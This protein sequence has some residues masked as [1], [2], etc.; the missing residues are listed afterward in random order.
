MNMTKTEQQLIAC[1]AAWR[2]GRREAPCVGLSTAQWQ[3]LHRLARL[4]K[5]GA[6]VCEMLCGLPEFCGGDAELAAAWRRESILDTVGQTRRTGGL[7]ELTRAL[8][9]EGIPYAVVKGAVCRELYARPDLRPSGDEDIL[10]RAADRERCD[11]LLTAAGMVRPPQDEGG[12]V[13]HYMA[14]TTGL[15]IELHTALLPGEQG[16]LAALDRYFSGQLDSTVS[17]AVQGGHVQALDPTSHLLFLVCHAL[18]HFVAG[19]VGVRTVCDVVTF[20]ERYAPEIHRE[21]VYTWLDRVHGRGFFDQL[22]ALGEAYLAFDRAGLGWELSTP[23]DYGDMLAD[24]L[25]AGIYGQSTMSRRHSAAVAVQAARHGSGGTLA[26]VFPGRE[27]L[28]GR[29]PVL[30]RAPLLLPVCWAH[31]LGAYALE[32]LRSGGRENSPLESVALGKKRTEMM[33]RYGII[34]KD[35]RKDQ[36]RLAP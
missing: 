26:A 27:Q 12:C 6:V 21:T 13:T 20:A 16:E 34:P 30:R 19:G 35:T 29:Y 1:L 4:H 2:L 9:Q 33:V 14:R 36:G 17:A 11:A 24:M 15:H 22:L 28:A 5:L 7:L 10:I 18:R 32:V 31:R 8:E 3:Q 23:P 25:D